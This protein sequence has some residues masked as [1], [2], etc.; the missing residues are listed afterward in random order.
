VTSQLDGEDAPGATPLEDDDLDGLIPTHVATRGDLN[1]VEQAN[2]E[3]ATRWAYRARTILP[4]ADLLTV[5][6]STEVH[7]QMFGEVWRWAGMQRV[8]EANIGVDPASIPTETKVLLDDTQYWHA[9][10]TYDAIG[11]AVR[12]HHRL[13]SVHPFRNGNGRHARFMADLYLHSIGLERLT[14]GGNRLTAD[15]EPRR[16]YLQA[17]RLADSGEVDSLIEFARS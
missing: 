8:R 10:E 17:L 3:R 13:V 1:I 16:A 9:H 12:L 4:I 11:R 14:W 5:S 7:R 15:G 2:I 6:L